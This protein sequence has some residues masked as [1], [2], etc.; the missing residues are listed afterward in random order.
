MVPPCFWALAARPQAAKYRRKE[1][2]RNRA[3]AQGRL[4]LFSLPDV[5]RPV[6]QIV[7]SLLC[8]IGWN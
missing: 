3:Q 2:P 1:Y 6:F 4:H 7:V 8:E 5:F